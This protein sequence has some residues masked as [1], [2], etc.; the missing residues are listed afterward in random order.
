[1]IGHAVDVIAEKGMR[2]G[3]SRG[4]LGGVPPT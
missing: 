4:Y 2:S 1:M 3:F